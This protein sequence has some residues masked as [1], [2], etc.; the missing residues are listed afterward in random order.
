LLARNP[1]DPLY[2]LKNVIHYFLP[3]G[4]ATIRDFLPRL[5]GVWPLGWQQPTA[6]AIF[7]EA[8]TWLS[9]SVDESEKQ[10]SERIERSLS[11]S[12]LY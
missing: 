1:T 2:P 5:T 10:L 9:G 3:L 4:I 7:L 6:I 11:T 12:H 8:N